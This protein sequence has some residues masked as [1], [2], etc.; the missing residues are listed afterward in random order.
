MRLSDAGLRQQQKKL[1]YPNHRSHSLV[2]RT[3]HPRSL[4]LLKWTPPGWQYGISVPS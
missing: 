2:Q 3:S 4:E 1:I